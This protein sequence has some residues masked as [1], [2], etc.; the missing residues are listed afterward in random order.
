[1]R[2]KERTS[3]SKI[4]RDSCHDNVAKRTKMMNMPDMI[5]QY[6]K[7]IK[8]ILAGSTNDISM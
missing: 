8:G 4:R 2:K 6:P 3:G 1:M 5:V 7:Y